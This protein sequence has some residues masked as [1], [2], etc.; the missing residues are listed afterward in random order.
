MMNQDRFAPRKML[1]PGVIIVA[2]WILGIA[3]WQSSGYIEALLH[4]GYIGTAVGVGIGLYNA[5][6]RKNKPLGRKLALFLVGGYMLI[7]L[8]LLG[9]ENIQIEWVFFSLLSGF[10]G[11]AL[12]HYLIA[13]IFGP[14][15]FGRLWCGWACWT[16]MILDLLPHNRS[17]GRVSGRWGHLRY[18]HSAL[19]LGLV[20]LVWFAFDYRDR[21]YY[22]SLTGLYWLLAGNALYYLVGITLALLLKDNRAFCKYLCPITVFLKATSRFSLLK[23]KGEG[24]KC[25]ECGACIRVCPM[26]IRIPDYVK[27]GQRVLS[28]ECTLCLTCTNTCPTGALHASFGFDIGGKE[29]LQERKTK[30]E[31]MT[32]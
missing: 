8:G 30:V 29:L 21:I 10:S 26:D 18:T 24:E 32:M 3:M 9:S 2:F 7:F 20:L 23:I 25:N 19:S 11:A 22:G 28:T 14:L 1:V 5:L 4:F 16:V 12:S 6:P 27:N 31:A 15:L 17:R 13:K